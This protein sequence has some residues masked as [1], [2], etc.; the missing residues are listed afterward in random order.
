MIEAAVSHVANELGQHLQRRLGETES[1]V[2]LSPL[3]EQDGTVPNRIDNKLVLMLVNIEKDTAAKNETA[4]GFG[5]QKLATRPPLHLNLHLLLAASFGDGNYTEALGFI[6]DAAGFLQ[7]RAVIT[8]ENSPDLDPRIER[9]TLEIENLTVPELSNLWGMLGGRYLPSIFYK[10][11]MITIASEGVTGVISPVR[12]P[13]TM[14]GGG[15]S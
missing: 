3:F 8:H 6:S 5:G 2:V 13:T 11:R 7:N 10:M 14:I 9:L 1:R 15:S 4:K 12:A